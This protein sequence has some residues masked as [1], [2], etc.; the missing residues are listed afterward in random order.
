MKMTQEKILHYLKELKPELEA[1]GI[2]DIALFG[3]YATQK[4]NLYS[5]IDIAI[6]K[7][8]DFLDKYSAYDYFN[9]ISNLK[10]KLLKELHRSSDV[11]DLDSHS[12]FKQQIEK[13]LI[14][15]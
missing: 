14:Y 4:E 9:L 5:D 11:F 15:V 3:S 6:R 13:E 7:K 1:K 8:E 2:A 12:S 10:T